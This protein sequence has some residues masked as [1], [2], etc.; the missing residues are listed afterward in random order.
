MRHS[1]EHKRKI[2]LAHFNIPDPLHYAECNA[3][4]KGGTAAW[5]GFAW[6]IQRRAA[7][8]RD[9]RRCVQCG[10]T[11]KLCVHHIKDKRDTGGEW[12]NSLPNLQVLCTICHLRLHGREARNFRV[13]CKV[14]GA[15]YDSSSSIPGACSLP[16]KRGL[17][18]EAHARWRRKKDGDFVCR[19]CGDSFPRR[20]GRSR[21]CSTKC[22]AIGRK[23]WMREYNRN[24]RKNLLV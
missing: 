5:R 20:N 12:D 4:W 1:E 24:Y 3:K 18:T 15:V 7:I 6:R 13:P 23:R 2:G 22:A 9:G 17:R 19:V 11:A 21:Y 14:C 8:E 16:C 10:A